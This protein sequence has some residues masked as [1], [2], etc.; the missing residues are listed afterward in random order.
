MRTPAL[1]RGF[2]KKFKFTGDLGW[3]KLRAELLRLPVKLPELKAL[4]LTSSRIP[5][6]RHQGARVFHLEFGAPLR[7]QNPDALITFRATKEPFSN[8]VVELASG[9]QH[10]LDVAGMQSSA[11]LERVLD[12]SGMPAA[13]RVTTMHIVTTQLK[14]NA[15]QH[16]SATRRQRPRATEMGLGVALS[17]VSVAW[18][19]LGGSGGGPERHTPPHAQGHLHPCPYLP[20]PLPL[21]APTPA[22]ERRAVAA[23]IRATPRPAQGQPHPPQEEGSRRVDADERPWR[24]AGACPQSPS[25]PLSH[26]VCVPSR[27]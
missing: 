9:E 12:V 25:P 7:Y 4:A 26:P 17:G 8:I 14:P 3:D 15:A 16:A 21:P 13:E 5:G 11:I 19:A 27:R 23:C 10:T 6:K 22:P 24:G 18:V 1:V 20:P 2:A